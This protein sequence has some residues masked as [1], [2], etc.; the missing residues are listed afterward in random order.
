MIQ[1]RSHRR[2]DVGRA[3]LLSGLGMLGLAPV[4]AATPVPVVAQPVVQSVPGGEGMK[5]NT[6]LGRLAQDPRDVDALIDAGRASLDLGDID[7]AIGFYQRAGA[8]APN[9]GR[10]KAGLAGAYV[11]KG[12]PFS[13]IPLF[14][15]AEQAGAVDAAGLAD[16]GLASDLVGDNAAAQQYYRRSLALAHSDET[17]RRLALSLAIAGDRRGMELTLSPLLAKQ[18]KI[19]WRTRAFG[20]AILGA[21]DEADGIA[22][23]SLPPERA[24]AMTAYLR[25]MPRLTAAQQAAAC[26]LGRFPRAAEIGIDDPRVARYAKPRPTQVALGPGLAAKPRPRDRDAGLTGA[27]AQ[28]FRPLAAPVPAKPAAPVEPSVSREVAGA[29]LSSPVPDGDQPRDQTGELAPVAAAPAVRTVLPVAAPLPA[30]KPPIQP[31]TQPA[32]RLE[33]V[34][35]D[36]TPPSREAE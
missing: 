8:L 24:S 28:P 29:P 6:A 22:R 4:G 16:R 3:A 5:L 14:A 18:D 12:D 1:V 10:A 17:V 27:T 20:L 2:L 34:F 19:A 25:Y 31:S 30:A 32:L 33:D 13:A 11:L 15:E 23:Q 36:F 21:I 7:A 35:A 9:N 26:N